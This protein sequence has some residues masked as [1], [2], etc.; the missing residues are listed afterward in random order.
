MRKKK[1]D[2][3]VK[4]KQSRGFSAELVTQMNSVA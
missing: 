1:K 3:S 2:P 4:E